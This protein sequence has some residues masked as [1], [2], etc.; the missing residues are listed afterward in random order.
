MS[1]WKTHYTNRLQTIKNSKTCPRD[2]YNN[3]RVYMYMYDL[4]MTSTIMCTRTH[5]FV[6]TVDRHYNVSPCE[7]RRLYTT[8]GSRAALWWT[9]ECRGRARRRSGTASPCAFR[10]S[11]G[12]SSRSFEPGIRRTK[13]ARTRGVP[14]RGEEARGW[15]LTLRGKLVISSA[16]AQ[17]YINRANTQTTS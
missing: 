17:S 12:S 5:I 4:C 15:R 13:Y 10:S 6:V 9:P 3:V 8:V 14:G 16:R 1:G 2:A 7:W 11:A